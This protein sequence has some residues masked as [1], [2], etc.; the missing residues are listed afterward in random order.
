MCGKHTRE[1]DLHLPQQ[2]Q[3]ITPKPGEPRNCSRNVF[4]RNR[5]IEDRSQ[6]VESVC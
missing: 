1:L 6:R 3:E 2:K 4:F 5:K